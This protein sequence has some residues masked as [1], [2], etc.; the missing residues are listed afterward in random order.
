MNDN[1]VTL[2]SRSRT[3]TTLA[4]V[5]FLNNQP[6]APIN[7][8]YSVIKL[9]MFRAT[10]LPIVSTVRMERSSILTLLGSGHQNPA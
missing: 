2:I 5:F 7:Q 9:Y 4:M 1:S 6:D 3:T 8:I 10:S